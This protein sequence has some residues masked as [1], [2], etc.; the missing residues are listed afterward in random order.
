MPRP[1]NSHISGHDLERYFL[2]MVVEESELASLEEHIL[3]C[4]D[5]ALRAQEAQEYVDIMRAS[6]LK[7]LGPG[8]LER[9]FGKRQK[10]KHA[11]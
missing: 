7:T 9:R 4:S 1:H 11:Q 2:G 10:R 8:E 6:L 5:C 3:S